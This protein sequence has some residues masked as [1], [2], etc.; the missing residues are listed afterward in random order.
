MSIAISG[1]AVTT[2]FGRGTEPLLAAA[3]TGRPGF[4][5]IDRFDVNGRRVSVAATLPALTGTAECLRDE[6]TVVIRTAGADAGLTEAELAATP[7]LLAL[8]GDPG[9][10]RVPVAERP[11][12]SPAAFAR[13][14]ATA[15]GTG[16]VLCTYTNACVAASTAVADAAASIAFEAAERFVVAAGYLVESDQFALFDAGR[17]LAADG[18]VR[19]FSAYRKGLLLGDGVAAIVVE[20]AAT[21]RRR[22]ANP[23]VWLRGW[24][25][26]GDAY[27]VCQPRPDGAGLARAIEAAL[28]R[29]RINPDDVGYINAHG[30]GS[31]QSD[32]AEAAALRHAL[33]QSAAKIP[34]SSTKAVHGQALE[35]SGL[36]EL[37]ITV[38]ALRH[39]RLP[40]NAGYLGPDDDCHLDL[41][42]EGPREVRPRY[43]LTLNAAFG[44]ANTAL[45]VGAA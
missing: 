40:M 44:G 18:Q 11:A 41:I 34:V 29:A 9:L 24:A 1:V 33:G 16:P 7:L 22:V 6:L 13:T 14:V 12:H 3:W 4:G 17:A 39:G 26:T 27:H 23:L 42:I 19:P 2:A 25:R 15:A 35:A 32:A 10:G 5:P 45:L 8:H 43:A 28:D 37:V 20:A 38:E 36:V 21:V 30:S 31:A